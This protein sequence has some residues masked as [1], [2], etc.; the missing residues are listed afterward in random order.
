[1]MPRSFEIIGSKEK[2]VAIVKI[3]K[4]EDERKIAEEIMKNNKNVKT[5]LKKVS[6]RKG[7]FRLKE[8]EII[9]G[10]EDTE[11][12]H[13]EHGYLLKL[14]PQLVYFSPKEATERQRIAEQV[15]ENETVL[16]MFGGIGALAVAIAKKQPKVKKIISIDSNPQAHEYAIENARINRISHLVYPISG[17]VNEVCKKFFGTF[18]RILMP[19]PLEAEKFLGLAVSCLKGRGIIHFYSIDSDQDLFSKSIEKI[20]KH[21]KNFKI[22]YKR[23]VLP[24]SPHKWKIVIDIKVRAPINKNEVRLYE[25]T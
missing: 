9:N 7:E 25:F 16:V 11:V 1:M 23:K 22:L 17:D 10:D 6:D 18:D 13:K 24:F 5:V 20:K 12:I 15:K 14:D 2:A 4:G 19:L 8:Y 3:P 21:I